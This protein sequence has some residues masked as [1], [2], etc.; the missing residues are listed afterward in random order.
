MLVEPEM[1]IADALNPAQAAL[2]REPEEQREIWRETFAQ[3]ES[4]LAE[5]EDLPVSSKIDLDAIHGLLAEVDFDH[6]MKATE[7]VRF[8]AEGLRRHQVQT[9]HPRYFGLFNPGS[10]TMGI[11]ADALVAA[12]NPQLASWSHNPFGNEIERRLVQ[13][14]GSKF[15]YRAPA[16]DGTFCT[17]G[18]EANHTALIAALVAKFPSF[19]QSGVRSLDGRPTLYVSQQAHHSFVKAARFCGL[20]ADAVREVPVTANATMDPVLLAELIEQDLW[21]G[22]RPF[23][24]AATLGTTNAGVVDPVVEIRNVARQFGLWFHTDAAWGGMAAFVPEL[25]YLLE[26]V[27]D[28]DSITFDA[29]KMLSVPMAAGMFFTK[30][31]AI[32]SEACRITTDYMPPIDEAAIDPY[33]HSIQWSRRFIGLKVFLSLAVAGWEGYAAALRH[34][35]AMADDLRTMLPK[36]GWRV[37]NETPLPTVCFV[38][39]EQELKAEHYAEMVRSIVEDGR[40]WISSTRLANGQPV[41]RACITSFRTRKEDLISLLDVLD[42]VRAKNGA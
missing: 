31:P 7:A 41:L 22:H 39:A 12:F 3:I 10:T 37:V 8:A 4:Y 15:G 40:V 18:A 23:F 1:K 21:D 34:Q 29:H 13:E 19:S 16:L 28:A 14:I 5:L 30:H 35:T 11:A 38:A 33:T 2:Q 27:G 42:E 6:R 36:R 26:G 32:L 17:G 20:G 25:G 9:P 24:V